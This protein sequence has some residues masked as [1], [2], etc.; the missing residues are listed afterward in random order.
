MNIGFFL[1][2]NSSHDVIVHTESQGAVSTLEAGTRSLAPG[3]DRDLADTR[4]EDRREDGEGVSAH[5][6]SGP[7]P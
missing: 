6:Q 2:H 4:I 7:G 3:S 5:T 1:S